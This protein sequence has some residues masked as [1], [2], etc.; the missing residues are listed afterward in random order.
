MPGMPDRRTIFRWKDQIPEFAEAVAQAAGPSGDDAVTDE[1]PISKLRELAR[2]PRE[3]I[4]YRAA[5]KLADLE[6]KAQ[7][8]AASVP[9]RGA[10]I[11]IRVY[12][13]ASLE[14]VEC[15]DVVR[16]LEPGQQPVLH[17]E[18]HA[19]APVPYVP[20]GD[21]VS[22]PPLADEGV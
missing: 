11:Y 8:E 19:V 9:Q 17:L 3:D 12:P 15:E 2:S 18:R 4:A 1:T 22:F 16:D 13:D 6:I 10:T 21:P 14:P 20:H 7:I 5:S